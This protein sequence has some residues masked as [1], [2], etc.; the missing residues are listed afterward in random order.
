MSKS[1]RRPWKKTEGSYGNYTAVI[2]YN[3]NGKTVAR[4][5]WG[6]DGEFS[7][8][9]DDANLIAAAPE[10]LEAL[11]GMIGMFNAV[12]KKVNWGSSFLDADAIRM[13]NEAPGNANQAI[14]KAEGKQ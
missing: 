10:L 2:G 11:K 4:I 14:N 1:T 13:M 5:P 9:D 7:T 8:D 12:G 3:C 6:T